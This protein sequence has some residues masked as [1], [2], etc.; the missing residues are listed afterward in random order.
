MSGYEAMMEVRF[1]EDSPLEESGFEPLVP[2]LNRHAEPAPCRRPPASVDRHQMGF[3]LGEA[4]AHLNYLIHEGASPAS[5]ARTTSTG[6]SGHQTR[7]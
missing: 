3:A 4:L 7:Q 1:A 6:L 5:S 2:L